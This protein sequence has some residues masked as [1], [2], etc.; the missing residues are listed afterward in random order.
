MSTVK[1]IAKDIRKSPSYA[2]EAVVEHLYKLGYS[3]TGKQVYQA[4]LMD[5]QSNEGD[6]TPDHVAKYLH[7]LGYSKGPRMTRAEVVEAFERS[8]KRWPETDKGVTALQWY[9]SQ[10]LGGKAG[11]L[12]ALFA[13]ELGVKIIPGTRIPG[14]V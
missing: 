10:E 4:L 6:F 12:L 3:K 5:V 13:E 9:W 2:T 11:D 1:Q 8:V 7:S 14:G